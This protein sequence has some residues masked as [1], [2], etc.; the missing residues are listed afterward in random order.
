VTAPTRTRERWRR[1]PADVARLV[2]ALAIGAALVGVEWL[3][4]D[5]LRDV[6]EDLVALAANVP[7]GLAGALVGLVQVMALVVPVVVVVALAVRKRLDLLGVV[8]LATVFSGL[9]MALIT[10]VVDEAAPTDVLSDDRLD[11]WF[12]GVRFPSAAYLAAAVGALVAA[13]PWVRRRWRRALWLFVLA[14]VAVRVLTATVVPLHVPL[15][16]AIGAAA[17]SAVLVIFGAPPRRV[18]L[19]TVKDALAGAGLEMHGLALVDEGRGTPTFRGEGPAGHAFVKVIGRDERDTDLLLRATRALRVKGLGDDRPMVSPERVVQHEALVLAVAAGAGA[20]APTPLAVGRTDDEVAVLATSWSDG[21]ALASLPDEAWTDGLLDDLWGTVALLQGR[22]IAHRALVADNV[23]VRDGRTT[24]VDF[25]RGDLA[26]SDL[27]LGADVAELLAETALR[28]GPQRAVAAATRGLP[29]EQLA[30][31]VPLLQAAVLRSSTRA[32]M[33]KRKGLLD[34]VRNAAAEAA[35]IEKVTLTPVHRITLK[36]AVTLLGSLV[37]VFYLLSIVSNWSD[38]WDSLSSADTSYLLPILVM[39]M[40][41]Y[42]SGALSLMGAITIDLPFLRTTAIMFA[43][44]FLNRFTP[45]NAGGMALRA[46]YLQVNGAD[47]TVAAASVGLTSAAS[48]VVQGVFIVVF[49]VWGGT[50]DAFSEI[51][52]PD[53]STVLFIL[54][55]VAAAIGFLVLSSWGKRVVMPKVRTAAGK[56]WHELK[57]LARDP[58]KSAQLLGGAAIGKLA[59][60]VAFYLSIRAFGVDMPFA[61][62]GAIYMVA[63]TIGSAV[64]TPG[65]VGGIEAALTAVLLSA[66]IDNADAAAI[67]L[68]FRFMT[69][70]LPTLPGWFFLQYVEKKQ[71][72]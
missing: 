56:A 26:A 1:H 14:V 27:L 31:A 57:A 23:L 28:V 33:R 54:V 48:G 35:G 5:E 66:G 40:V 13:T 64:P 62:A 7:S 10:A 20:G 12:V 61:Q 39:A 45:A 71:I 17:G 24:L 60:I 34:E 43:Q 32:A 29:G 72:V 69:F 46:R 38:I 47:L 44:S 53:T 67:V 37:L 2:F 36:G 52:L 8:A 15:L 41:P 55:A 25:R 18:D 6:S 30:R 21:V 59:T 58:V 4:G 65:G 63:N 3:A 42:F 22:R 70:W 9:V 50:T 51:S 16:I 68:L 11:E 49:F 19:V